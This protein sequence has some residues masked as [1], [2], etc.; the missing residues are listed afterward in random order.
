MEKDVVDY[1]VRCIECQRVKYEFRH[2]TSLVCPFLI[3]ENKWEVVTIDF[4]ITFPRTTRKPD[5][6]MVVVEKLRKFAHFFPVKMTHT[7][8]NIA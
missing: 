4:I 2:P 3:L 8:T 6:I 7:T 1:T 5:S